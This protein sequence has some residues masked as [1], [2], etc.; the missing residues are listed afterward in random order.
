MI[1]SSFFYAVVS[2]FGFFLENLKT[3]FISFNT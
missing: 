1:Y 2:G 3:P